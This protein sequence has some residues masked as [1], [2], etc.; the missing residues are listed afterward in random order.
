MRTFP[1]SASPDEAVTAAYEAMKRFQPDVVVTIGDYHETAWMHAIKSLYPQLFKWVAYLTVNSL[2][3]SREYA[4]ALSTADALLASTEEASMAVRDLTGVYCEYAPFG[5]DPNIFYANDEI[6]DSKEFRVIG[7]PKNSQSSNIGAW[8]SS[9]AN[10]LSDGGGIR[11]LLHTNLNDPG[12]YAIEELLESYEV[13]EIIDL[14]DRYVSVNEGL[15]DAEMADLYRRHHVVMDLSV[16]SSTAIG[17]LEAMAC[18]CLPLVAKHGAIGEVVSELRNT[19]LVLPTV[20]FIGERQEIMHI[21]ETDE[22]YEEIRALKGFLER[23]KEG[24]A[25]LRKKSIQLAKRYSERL[26]ESQ[27]AA[28]IGRVTKQD[29]LKLSVDS[30]N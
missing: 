3:I 20:P 17:V 11:A 28:C 6:A 8:V 26:A 25:E 18:G 22:I 10:G 23:D 16:R 30:L 21:V 7:T 14:P 15:T 19:G 1:I 13:E 27:I 29:R 2:P 24:Y 9:F 5:P 12:D 4:D